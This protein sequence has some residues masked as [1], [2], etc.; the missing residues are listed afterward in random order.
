MG[1]GGGGG[2]HWPTFHS[3]TS[4]NK[5][6]TIGYYGGGGGSFDDKDG[7]Y[8]ASGAGG[9]DLLIILA[10]NDPYALFIHLIGGSSFTE[11]CFKGFIENTL[12]NILVDHGE[13]GTSNDV[14][15]PGK[16]YMVSKH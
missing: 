4:F 8:C 2:S 7:G 16:I 3:Y 11:G 14:S 10:K 1:A 5:F 15:R 12:Y 9:N 13:V 6:S